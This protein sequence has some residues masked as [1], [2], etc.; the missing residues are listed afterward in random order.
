MPRQAGSFVENSFVKGLITEATG[1]NFPEQAVTETD[2]CIFDEKGTVRRRLGIDLEYGYETLTAARGGGAVTAYRWDA[3]AGSGDNTIVVIQ[4][5]ATLYFYLVDDNG[6]VSDNEFAYLSLTTYVPA[7]SNLSVS[8]NECQYSAGKGFLFIA[9]EAME[10]IY[11]VYT[12]ETLTITA[13]QIDLQ[14]RDFEGVDDGLEVSAQPLTLSEAHEYNLLNQ[15]WDIHGAGASYDIYPLDSWFGARANYP[16]NMEIWWTLVDPASGVFNAQINFRDYGNT[17]AP[18]GHF[19]LDYY[20]QDRNSVTPIQTSRTIVDQPATTSGYYRASTIAFFA[21]R[22]W[23]SGVRGAGYSNRILF[24]QIIERDSQIGQ[25]YQQNDPTAQANFDLLATDGGTILIP[26]SG[27]IIKLLD[28]QDSMLVFA[29][30][31]VWAISGSQGVGFRATDYSI[32]KVSNVGCF[33]ASSFVSIDGLPSFWNGEGIYFINQEQS[34]AVPSVTPITDSSIRKFYNDIPYESK[35]FARGAYNRRTRIISW[36]Y[37]STEATSNTTAYHFDKVLNF[38]LLSKAFYGW[39][40]STSTYAAN[41]IV[42]V[43]TDDT[44]GGDLTTVTNSALATVTNSALA[45]VSVFTPDQQKG[46]V[47]KFLVSKVN[48]GSYDF[49]FADTWNDNY[50]DWFSVD[51]VGVNFTSSLTTGY[52][53]HGD[54]LRDVSPTYI[55]LFFTTDEVASTVDFQSRWQYALN[56]STGRWSSTQ[57]LITDSGDYAFERKRIKSRG[58][59]IVYQ[60]RLD[61]VAGLPFNLIGW[62]VFETTNQTV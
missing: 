33:S 40:L 38:N 62:S 2:N 21:G 26:D 30:N 53:I 36:L 32:I 61:S 23:Y 56:G 37:R 14:T 57:R 54:G 17:P 5:G 3:A 22:V 16:S 43:I 10:S 20:F 60:F 1:L 9:N 28:F 46:E 50:V 31:G 52:K 58:S 6:A 25:C 15:G 48:G 29:T 4:V 24:S 18:K 59:G 12:P 19:I 47:F 11:C 41:A 39:S 51:L 8:E 45:T 13:T 34:S 27:T 44:A 7:G 42:S 49:T 55:N 35:R